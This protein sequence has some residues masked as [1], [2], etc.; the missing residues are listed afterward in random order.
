MLHSRISFKMNKKWLKLYLILYLRVSRTKWIICNKIP[1]LW[2]IVEDFGF[3]VVTLI[4]RTSYKRRSFIHTQS[5]HPWMWIIW[6]RLHLDTFSIEPW[7]IVKS[8]FIEEQLT[9]DIRPGNTNDTKNIKEYQM[10]MYYIPHENNQSTIHEFL[11][12]CNFQ[13]CS[14]KIKLRI[15]FCFL[16]ITCRLLL[17][18]PITQSSSFSV[19]A[20]DP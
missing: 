5:I 20:Q 1:L 19:A 3:L 15:S 4:I 6:R 14:P 8:W 13:F 16:I 17:L 7:K 10:R 2:S 11:L 12:I 9:N 18:P